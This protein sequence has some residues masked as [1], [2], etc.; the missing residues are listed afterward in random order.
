MQF[1][2]KVDGLD[3]LRRRLAQS[4]NII[5][6]ELKPALKQAGTVMRDEAKHLA[7]GNR[8]PNSVQMRTL[9]SGLTQIVGSVAK[10]ALSIETGRKPGEVVNVG[11]ITGW[12]GRKGIVAPAAALAGATQSIK[13]HKVMKHGG[14]PVA[15]AQRD[16]AWKIAMAIREHGTKPLPF[17]IPAAQHKKDDV[18]KLVNV[19]IGRALH[20]MARG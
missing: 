1:D 19:A 17:I 6:A 3:G 15:R 13:R 4:V 16:L 5:D 10:T 11:L 7:P 8:L 9:N 12:M 2:I 20:R 18:Q 14:K